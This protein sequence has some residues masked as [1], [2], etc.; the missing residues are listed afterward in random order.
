MEKQGI[1][2]ALIKGSRIGDAETEALHTSEAKK[3]CGNEERGNA[4]NMMIVWRT[5]SYVHGRS[6]IHTWHK[7]ISSE[8]C[9]DKWA[10]AEK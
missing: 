1:G 6:A 2:L 8:S 10:S 5:V 9:P 3:R 4:M 7:V